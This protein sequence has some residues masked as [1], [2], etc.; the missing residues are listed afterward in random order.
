MLKST[1]YVVLVLSCLGVLVPCASA[2]QE[3]ITDLPKHLEGNA[4]YKGAD[5]LGKLTYLAKLIQDKAIGRFDYAAQ[6]ESQLLVKA[7]M[8]EKGKDSAKAK[9]EA[10]AELQK[11]TRDKTLGGLRLGGD[12]VH[13]TFMKFL[14]GSE[15]YAKASDK[16]KLAIF[17]ELKEKGIP[18][19]NTS[20]DEMGAVVVR[21]ITRVS[22]DLPAGQRPL[23]K[24]QALSQLK[25]ERLLNWGP[26]YGTLEEMYLPQHL[27][28]LK[29]YET[30]SSK[31]KIEILS[32]MQKDGLITS[33]LFS[34]RE[35]VLL[36]QD[37]LANEE[38][39]KADDDAKRVI[40][41]K[42]AAE[43]KIHP[44][45]RNPLRRLLGL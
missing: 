22:R 34:A 42:V 4:A 32:K 21:H 44:F 39:V 40:V 33:F 37:L 24:L 31:E 16:G 8:Q 38:F 10:Y 18:M 5:T 9:L 15:E 23:K 20:R 45:T 17:R 27:L 25:E 12:A 2:K 14:L 30:K 35:G 29:D 7:Y 43:R 19:S 13:T 26:Y 6:K 36:S 3:K 11:M 28:T 41:G 1:R